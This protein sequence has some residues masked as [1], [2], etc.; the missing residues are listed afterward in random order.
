[1][2]KVAVMIEKYEAKKFLIENKLNMNKYFLQEETI[3]IFENIIKILSELIIELKQLTD[4]PE[5][6]R[7]C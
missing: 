1:M 5:A 6:E 2:K 4:L 3:Q 7:I